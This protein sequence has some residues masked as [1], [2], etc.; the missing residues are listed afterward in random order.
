MSWNFGGALAALGEHGIKIDHVGRAPKMR[1]CLD[2]VF[3]EKLHTAGDVGE[4]GIGLCAVERVAHKGCDGG[5]RLVHA[6][7]EPGSCQEKRVLAKSRR[8]VDRPWLGA[9]SD[10]RRANEQ[11]A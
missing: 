11:L 1:H 7:A 4:I 3:L 5:V 10:L 9:V 8:G 2:A 6:Y